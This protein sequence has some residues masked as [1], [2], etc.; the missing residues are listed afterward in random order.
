MGQWHGKLSGDNS[1]DLLM[2][3]D[4]LQE[5]K[6]GSISVWS[7]DINAEVPAIARIKFSKT[8]SDS[9]EAELD[10]FLGF[11]DRGIISHQNNQDFKMSSSGR[12]FDGKIID[13]HGISTLQGKWETNLGFRGMVKLK[14]V[15]P[16]QAEKIAKIVSW[17]E[18]KNALSNK[19]YKYGTYFRGQNDSSYPL[20]TR[21]HR[22][23][24]WDLYRHFNEAINELFDYMGVLNNTR[25]LIAN[26]VDFGSALLLAQHHKYPTPLL[27]W[28]LSPYIAAY[29]AFRKTPENNLCRSVRVFAFHA[30][31]WMVEKPQYTK[32][33]FVSP[34][35]ILKPLNIPL[36]GN[37]R[38]V[39]QVSRAVFS[40]VENI[41]KVLSWAQFDK[42]DSESMPE[43]WLDYFDI[44]I[45]EREEALEDLKFM[46]I[47]EMAL[48]Q[49]L[50]TAGEQLGKKYFGK[51]YDKIFQHDDNHQ[52]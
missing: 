32:G 35:I 28:T 51:Y 45:N 41:E 3:I 34:G 52:T 13:D 2:S 49:D 6:I 16:P 20:R 30:D 37:K 9:V 23:G 22:A 7:S 17:N 46:H 12:F 44:G 25:Y 47:E 11:S 5:D 48:F 50:D 21:F 43:S 10:G 4:K 18:F 27:D 19:Q 38:A 8:Q 29:F 31:R 36:S 39:A 26:D 40:N 14:K 1:S 42:P 24:C 33:G 15:P